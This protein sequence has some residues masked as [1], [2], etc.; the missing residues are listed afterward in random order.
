MVQRQIET[1]AGRLS[2]FRYDLKDEAVMVLWRHNIVLHDVLGIQWALPAIVL[3]ASGKS[4]PRR[5]ELA[6]PVRT[7]FRSCSGH[8]A[9]CKPMWPAGPWA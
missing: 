4:L 1:H 7:A 2:G 8:V 5:P 3:L 6:S 9:P